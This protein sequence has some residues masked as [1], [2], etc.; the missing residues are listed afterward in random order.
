[1]G[2]HVIST[3]FLRRRAEARRQQIKRW[4]IDAKT[5]PGD[6]V[7]ADAAA[8]LTELDL[9]VSDRIDIRKK[10]KWDARYEVVVK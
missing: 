6:S 8:K 2:D 10:G 7:G 4:Q 9:H 5:R 3:H 1:M